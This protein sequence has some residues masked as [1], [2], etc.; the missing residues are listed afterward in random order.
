MVHKRPDFEFFF[1]QEAQKWLD[2]NF[3]GELKI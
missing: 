2:E 3:G 1:P